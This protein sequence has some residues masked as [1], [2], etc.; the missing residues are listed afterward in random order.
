MGRAYEQGKNRRCGPAVLEKEI[1]EKVEE[2]PKRS[3]RL[4]ELTLALYV[5]RSQRFDAITIPP[6]S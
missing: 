6:P 5:K 1:G 2:Y 3:Y 4:Y